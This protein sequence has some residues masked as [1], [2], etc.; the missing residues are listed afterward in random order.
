MSFG[1][2]SISE[3]CFNYIR[4]ILPDGSTI[5]EFGSGFSTEQ[6]SKYYT[7][8]SVENYQE[9]V[10]KYD[11]TYIYAPIR[12]YEI[13]GSDIFGDADFWTAPEDI[14]GEQTAAQVGWYDPDIVKK[15]LPDKYDLILVD[16]P[17]GTF[18]RAGFYKHL[19]WFNT[20]IPIIIDDTHR[21][22]ERIMMEKISKSVGREYKILSDDVT[23]VIE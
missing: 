2:W 20:D 8:Y 19:E 16:G 23:G 13:G 5:L 22:A 3:I 14:P 18:G 1:G 11:A 15:N 12:E 6:L 7:M 4:E 21:D 9:W 17:N 10:G